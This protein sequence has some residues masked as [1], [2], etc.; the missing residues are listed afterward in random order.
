MR[1]VRS[2]KT[3]KETRREVNDVQEAD[4]KKRL[5]GFLLILWLMFPLPAYPAV[6]LETVKEHVNEVLDLLRDPALK[7]ESGKK[8]KKEKIR[9]ISEKMFDFGELSRRD[10]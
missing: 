7:G 8:A 4:V 6:P 3:P 5:G 9:S 10:L 1:L 2:K